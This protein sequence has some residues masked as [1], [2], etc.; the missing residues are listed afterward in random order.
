MDKEVGIYTTYKQGDVYRVEYY[1]AMR[2]TES[3]TF[4]AEWMELEAIM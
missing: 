4:A 1:L 2:R 3:L